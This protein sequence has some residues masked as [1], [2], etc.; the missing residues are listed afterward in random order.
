VKV[1][2]C[3]NYY[4]QPGGE[5]QVFA[6][7]GRLLEAHGHDVLRYTLHNDALHDMSGAG[8]ARKTV[9]NSQSAAE[10]G[11]I[12]R[13]ESPAIVHFTN[14]FPLISPAAY[15]AARRGGAAVVQS[16]HNYRLLCPSAVFLRDGNVCEECLGR[17]FA[18]PGVVHACYHSSRAATGVVAA[19]QTAHR[20]LGTWRR[21]VD[22]YIALT[23][24]ARQKFI[25]G[26]LPAERVSVKGNFVEPDPGPG[27]GRGDFALFVGRL[28]PEKGLD[29]LLAAWQKLPGRKLVVLGD[30]PLAP[31]V[32][33]AAAAN[34]DVQWLGRRSRAEVLEWLGRASCVIVPSLWYEM[35]GMVVIEAFARG[36][37]VV[38]ARRGA[39]A[40]LVE[41]ERTGLHFAPGDPQELS[42]AAARLLAD[43]ALQGRMRRA[44]RAEYERRH[45]AAD[46]YAQLLAIYRAARRQF[47]GGAPESN[48]AARIRPASPPQV[49]S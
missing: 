14:T 2:L 46:N 10:I 4:Q 38:A 20:V 1:L 28:S 19:L 30:G 9:W 23:E 36:T 17:R 12:V 15:Y 32:Q 7:E 37:P 21:A 22:R 18:W 25:A 42:R 8:A 45:T 41:H 44:A 43:G 31:L 29:T 16:L 49:T 34:P 40:E 48:E 11:A 24:F 26:G 33:T 13:R 5:D 35:F 39:L 47:E 3:H 27:E 6:D